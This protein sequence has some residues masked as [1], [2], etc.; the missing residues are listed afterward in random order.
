MRISYKLTATL[1]D[2]PLERDV[3]EKSRV[4]LS[5][6]SVLSIQDSIWAAECQGG[7][8]EPDLNAI[9]ISSTS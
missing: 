2:S 3:F 5:K 9:I 7:S 1:L 4:L 6:Q 8:C